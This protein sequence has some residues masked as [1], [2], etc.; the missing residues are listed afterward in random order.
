MRYGCRADNL[1]ERNKLGKRC[2][3]TTADTDEHIIETRRVKTVFWCSVSHDTIDLTELIEV[4][5]ICTT[6][7]R[8]E[9]AEHGCR[10]DSCTVALRSIDTHFVFR[11]ALGVGTHSHHDFRSL[12]ELS[13]ELIGSI[14][15]L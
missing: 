6:T 7:V 2:H 5:Y 1:F 11:E 10:C 3:L 8:T 13:D 4:T 14:V 12:V 15:E 9:S